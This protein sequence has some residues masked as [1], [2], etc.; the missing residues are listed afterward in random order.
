MLENLQNYFSPD[1]IYIWISFGVLPFWLALIVFPS[2]RIASIFISSIFL[3]II[4]SLVYGYLFY[5]L[6]INGEN[7]LQIFDTYLGIENLHS[8]FSN[9]TFLAIF[10]V[11]FLGINLFF[12]FLF[13]TWYSFDLMISKIMSSFFTLAWNFSMR[14]YYVFRDPTS[15]NKST[16]PTS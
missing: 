16:S 4:F 14:N 8:L 9:D 2:S 6:V 10:W 13:S 12:L 5:L 1:V 7:L 11:H 3:P 15:D